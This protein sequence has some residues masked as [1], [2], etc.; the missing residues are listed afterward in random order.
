MPRRDGH[1]EL[2][3]LLHTHMPYVEGFDRW[4]FGEEWLWEAIATS[5]LPLV[6]VL[7]TGAPLTVSLTPVLC[8]QL[9]VE[10]LA[11]RLRDFLGGLRRETHRLDIELQRAQGDERAAAELERAAGDY[12]RALAS[13]DRIGGD[14]LGALA[15][16]AQWTSAATHAV[17]PL[18]ATDAGVALQVRSGIGSHRARFSRSWR[19]G[20]WLPECAHA[21]WLEST[22][23]GAGVRACCVEFTNLLGLGAPTHLQPLRGDCGV[24]LVP[25]DRVMIDLVWGRE[26]YPSHPSYRDSHALTAHHHHVRANDGSV[27]DY[28]VALAQARSDAG[29]FVARVR[30][31]LAR[32]AGDLADGGLVVCALDTELLGHWWYEG[33]A[34]VQAVVQEAE[35]Q[36]LALVGL[37]DALE[38][39]RPADLAAAL[40]APE[41]RASSWGEGGDLRTWDA[42]AVAEMAWAA[43]AAELQVVGAPAAIAESAARHLLGTQASDWAFLVSRDLA[44]SY[45]RDRAARHLAAMLQA[46]AGHSVDVGELRNLAVHAPPSA[47]LG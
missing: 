11:P 32:D 9:E 25:I 23:A 34:W 19:G 24:T 6:E 22:L 35:R 28:A 46:C 38:R 2:A 44:V 40:G 1:G 45:G 36:G 4:P 3:L 7:E 27:Y 16:F 26:G 37:D 10:D 12:E 33:V 42:P 41:L 17:L 5:Y 8:D 14:V 43:R 18:L 39:H 15:P 29:D 21:P 13:V 47:L 31:R 30:E 20:F